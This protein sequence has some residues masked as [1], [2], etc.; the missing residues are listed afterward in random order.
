M[1]RAKQ[2]D[3]EEKVKIILWFREGIAPKEIAS[4][5]QRNVS[6]VRKVIRDNKTLPIMA[7]PP[8]PK[9]RT[10]RPAAAAA[11]QEERLKAVRPQTS[12]QNGQGAEERGVRV[13]RCLHQD[14]PEGLPEKA[15]NAL[16][17]RR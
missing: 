9:K 2:F 3:V 6:A 10:G 4:R 8:S 11:T 5:L 12:F 15:G 1:P 7:T 13:A 17:Q 14:N 16:S